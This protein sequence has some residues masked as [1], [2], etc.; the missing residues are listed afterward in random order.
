MSSSTQSILQTLLQARTYVATTLFSAQAY[1]HAVELSF[2]ILV[3]YLALTRAYK[4]WK[5]RP[6]IPQ[7][8][9]AQIAEKIR[10]WN[11]QPLAEPLPDSITQALPL[12]IHI[13]DVGVDLTVTVNGQSNVLNLASNNFLALAKHPQIVQACLNTMKD[14]GLGACGP[15]GFY[16]T[17]DLHLECEDRL[18]IFSDTNSAILY[19][20]GAATSNSTIPAFCKRGDLIVVDENI[21]FILQSGV[22][23]SRAQVIQ[24]RHNDMEHLEE[25]LKEVMNKDEQGQNLLKTQRRLILVEGIYQNTGN[26]CPLDKVV[27][28]KKKYLFR[29]MLDESFSLGVLGKTGRGALEHF[30]ISRKQVDIATADMGNAIASVGGFCVGSEDV[31]SHQRLSGAGYCFSASQPPF[32]ATAATKALEIITK[33]GESLVGKLRDNIT[34]FR[35]CLDMKMLKEKGWYVDGHASSPIM[36]IRNYDDNFA[37][38]KFKE[39]QKKCLDKGVLVSKPVYTVTE[40]NPPKPSLKVAVSSGHSMARLEMA[41]GVIKDVLM[42]A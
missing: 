1:Y 11:P 42:N 9:E 22:S 16:G 34:I 15:R 23:L 21:N 20:F 2:L 5:D 25:I 3:I 14:Y 18:S 32:L 12:D 8:T 4:P 35:K 28:L 36:H 38:G 6:S 17:T 29:L 19:S 31:V 24:F 41:A 7:L 33:E 26:I 30:G 40:I 13:N 39:L 27:A 37:V 10:D